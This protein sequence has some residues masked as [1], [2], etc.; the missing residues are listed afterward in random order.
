MFQE[1]WLKAENMC[2]FLGDFW[3]AADLQHYKLI[4]H[5][6]REAESLICQLTRKMNTQY[7]VGLLVTNP[8]TGNTATN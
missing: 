7:Y 8:N 2:T 6:S 1:R 5:V 3:I 4:K